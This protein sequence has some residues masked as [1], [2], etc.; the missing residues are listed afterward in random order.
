MKL[1]PIPADEPERLLMLERAGI[2]DTPREPAFDELV[3]QAARMCGTPISLLTFVAEREMWIKASIGTDIE[4]IPRDV[5]LCAHTILEEDVLEV[6]DTH[7]DQ[8]FFDSPLVTSPPFIRFYAGV[9]IRSNQQHAIGGLCVVDIVPRV[10]NADQ[11]ELLRALAHQA[12]TLVEPQC[13]TA[14][15]T[16]RAE[17][18]EEAKARLER[19]QALLSGVLRA[20]TEYAII[21]CAPSGTINVFNEGAERMLGYHTDE[22][23]GA[24]P[25]LFHDAEEVAA[26]AA[27]LG[28]APEFE[29]FV[30][31]ARHGGAEAREW[32]YIRKDGRRIPV[33][34]TVTAMHDEAG[35]LIGF[36]GIARDVTSERIAER[37]RADVLIERAG[38]AAA[39]RSLAWL[40]RLHALTVSLAAAATCQ[41]VIDVIL[42]QALAA[43]EGV[44]AVVALTRADGEMLD[45][46][47]AVGRSQSQDEI[48][49]FPIT[50][51]TPVADAVRTRA[52]VLVE[53]LQL[54]GRYGPLLTGW[55]AGSRSL[56]AAPL[57]LTGEARPLGGYCF[58][59]AEPRSFREEDRL[60]LLALGRVCAQAVERV[61][62]YEAEARARREAEIANR[63][64]DE[65]LSTLSHELRTPLTAVLGWAHLLQRSEPEP[66]RVK[67]GLAVIERN[68]AL[69]LRL[70][71]DLLDISR[72]V[73]NDLEI[74]R[75][76][77]DLTTI[78]G[79]ALE[80]AR[81]SAEAAGVHLAVAVDPTTG[82]VLGDAD[83]LQQA[84]S[85]L[86]SNALKFTPRG[87]RIDVRLD[88]TDGRARVRLT[89]TG[90]GIAPG[91]L[92]SIFDRF[93]Q[94][95]SSRTR[96]H[97]GLG[98]GL[99]IARHL[100][101][102]HGGTLTAESEGAGT[103]ATFTILLPRQRDAESRA[104]NDGPPS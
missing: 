36:V 8:R 41:Q 73:A 1:P 74:K 38:R 75:A 19:E 94:A 12:A 4:E 22:L 91:I 11:R 7:R 99:A 90:Q 51:P 79:G 101:E 33:S 39:E 35:Q 78:I 3:L 23:N 67:H 100:V 63:T 81:P 96:A 98:L 72:I 95:D 93:R 71:E 2:L 10:L 70:I 5:A 68:A 29:V 40:G 85:N 24:S 45:L 16:A 14:T 56:V 66:E 57:L 65:F 30:V 47:G 43:L 69:Q 31:M 61:H 58:A 88:R 37:Q 27:E 34:L 104:L 83:R 13:M 82:P 18:A 80:A 50:S 20:A 44:S 103:G 32:T 59:F 53:D 87:G 21:G 89:D 52:T 28:I 64:K 92:P 76:P 25:L 97:G 9:P 6:E 42:R 55:L 15:V 17:E 77:V 26:R 60:F 84:V 86:L 62:L 54:G 48:I 102:L 49:S 46:V